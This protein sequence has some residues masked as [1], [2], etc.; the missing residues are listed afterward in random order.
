MS[1]MAEIVVAASWVVPVRPAGVLRDHAVVIGGGRI[2]DLLPTALA[3]QRYANVPCEEHPGHV[4]MPG[5]VN[6]HTHAAMT[7]MRGFADDLPLMEWL[8][9]HVWPAE[10]RHLS[11]Q[12]VADGT[13]L[14]CA[15]M[16][17]G[18]VT[19]FNDMYFFPEAVCTAAR[20]A[21]LRVVAGLVAVDF[22]TPYAADAD[23]GLARGLAT[24]QAFAGEPLVHFALAP[25]APYTVGDELFLRLAALGRE[26]GLRLHC[27]VHETAAEVAESLASHGERPLARLERLGILGPELVAV[28]CVHLDAAEIA[29]LAGHGVHV[30]H[31]PTSNLK[32]AS[33]LAPTA[34]LRLAGVNVGLGTDSAAS[35]NRVDLFGER[36]LAARLA[37]GVSGDATAWRA[38]EVLQAATL[39][40][41]MALGLAGETG[42]LEVGK[43]ADLV[44]VDLAA[45]TLQP[46]FDPLSHLVHVAGRDQV[47]EV[48]VAG[49]RKVR[50][51]ELVSAGRTAGGSVDALQSLA[52]AWADRLRSTP[53]T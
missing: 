50:G 12:F 39:D 25:H 6:L 35:N 40:G 28:H 42:S 46:V 33:G 45:P 5:L 53:V 34:A 10:A 36:R 4:M 20:E 41:A 21:G 1:S 47:R 15:E 7:L 3:R 14:A 17:L 9:R 44:A 24:R 30:A 18:G 52:A 37:K 8:R 26:E 49:E 29:M 2:L 48:W 16:L 11:P 22:A 43:S 23:T 27:H 13:R 32:L 31:C 38:A 19:T 51:G